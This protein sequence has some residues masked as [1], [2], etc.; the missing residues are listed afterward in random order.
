MK[1]VL[2]AL[3]ATAAI[4]TFALSEDAE[5]STHTVKSGD[6]LWSIATKNN[7]SV[8]DLKDWNN[9]SSDIILI[10]QNITLNGDSSPSGAIN[11]SK[12]SNETTG[13][14]YTV[15]PGDSLYGIGRQYDINYRELMELNHLTSFLIHPGDKLTISSNSESETSVSNNTEKTDK[16]TSNSNKNNNS[17][18]SSKSS[19]SSQ[20]PAPSE[21]SYGTNYYTWGE[22]TWYA[23]ERRKELG[24]AV[25]NSW[26]NATNWAKKARS[27]G[28]NVSNSP[29]VGAIMQS[30]AWT[31]HSYDLG[32]VAIVERINPDGSIL[33]SEMNFGGGQGNK[34][35]RTISA[36]SASNHN[37]IH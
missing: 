21:F 9:L 31:N 17:S 19:N 13:A 3:T 25:S 4:S 6:T 2:T 16:K 1:K 26:G 11:T 28:Y 23:F 34:V 7:I 30:D 24:K 14:T 36:S 33:V 20:A 27:D 37:F 8:E 5:A 29:S 10:N 32:H 35:F 18:A 22:C 15:K 12:S